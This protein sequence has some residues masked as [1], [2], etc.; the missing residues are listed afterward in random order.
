MIESAR[1]RNFKALRDVE[2]NLAPFTVLVGPNASGKSSILEALHCIART[3][4]VPPQGVFRGPMSPKAMHSRGG[5]GPIELSI[6]SKWGAAEGEFGITMTPD[7]VSDWSDW[8]PRVLGVWKEG[9]FAEEIE[10]KPLT[11]LIKGPWRY[12][13]DQAN[14]PLLRRVSSALLLHLEP[15][16]LAAPSYSETQRP[17]IEYDGTGLGPVMADIALSSPDDWA[18]LQES[19]RAVIPSVESMRLERARVTQTEAEIVEIGGKKSEF[20]RDREY[21]GH[22]VVLDMQG[23]PGLYANAAS[24]GTLL[25]IG[26]MTALVQAGRPELVLIDDLERALHPKALGNLVS[27]LRS[28]QSR[29]GKTRRIQIIATSHSPYLLDHFE[30][31]EIRLTTTAED[32]S[33]LCAPLT[34]HPDFGRWRDQMKTGEFWSTTGEDWIANRS[35]RDN[36]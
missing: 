21:W 12:R 17:R 15:R 7:E 19:V 22:R 4:S 31:E 2:L 3:A 14:S 8:T 24:E 16:K 10:F 23:A 36:G 1:F 18:F 35:D 25:T 20:E 28:V 26:L 6:K 11:K 9:E 29:F 34:D 33:C 5:T 30:P 27:Q 32:G 13:P